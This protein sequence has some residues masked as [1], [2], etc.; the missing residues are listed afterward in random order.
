[1]NMAPE[2][3]RMTAPRRFIPFMDR[4]HDRIRDGTKTMTLRSRE[5]G[6][7]G[8]ILASPVGPLRLV[9]PVEEVSVDFIAR[10][11]WAD[12]GCKSEADFWEVWHCLHPKKGEEPGQTAYLHVFEVVDVDGPDLETCLEPDRHWPQGEDT[13]ARDW[14]D[15]CGCCLA[16]H[17]TSCPGYDAVCPGGQP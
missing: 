1:M 3:S 13:L 14:C 17:P 12:E 7:Q 15:G 4:F 8:D 2:A 10:N 16:C 11:H 5:Y 6:A 9:R